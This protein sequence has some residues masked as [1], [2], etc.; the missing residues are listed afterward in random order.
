MLQCLVEAASSRRAAARSVADQDKQSTNSANT[1]VVYFLGWAS[2][3]TLAGYASVKF[4]VLK[5]GHAATAA[6]PT[7]QV[8]HRAGQA[9]HTGQPLL[10]PAEAL[11]LLERE[12]SE[13][14]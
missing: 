9:G 6:R 14:V 12:V 11:V 7:G 8:T 3:P 10:A 4:V 2:Q 13:S 1:V 5:L